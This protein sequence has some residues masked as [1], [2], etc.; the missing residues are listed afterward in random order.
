MVLLFLLLGCS[1]PPSFQG[2]TPAE[3]QPGE[4]VTLMGDDMD[5]TLEG[6]LL[7]GERRIP[8]GVSSTG[9]HAALLELPSDLPS[10]TYVVEL[11]AE[12]K[13]SDARHEVDVW[14]PET[15]RPCHKRYQLQTE[16]SRLPPKVS[17]R[18]G[19]ADGSF[20]QHQFEAEVISHLELAPAG[21]GCRALWL[22]TKEGG[23]RWL[24]ADDG[25]MPLD[26]AAKDLSDSLGIGL[27][28]R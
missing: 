16:A 21:E 7:Q 9:A 18:W 27:E 24:L 19:F 22:V 14:R 28:V 5:R 17:I 20:R 13:V 6:H 26:V 4:V 8:V 11:S 3:A 15:E 23:Q 12:G 10:G 2:V 25:A 1:Y